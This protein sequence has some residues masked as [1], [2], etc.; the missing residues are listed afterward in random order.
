MPDFVGYLII[1]ELRGSRAEGKH[2]GME[3]VYQNSTVWQV[4]FW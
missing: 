3:G 4:A 1:K 2:A